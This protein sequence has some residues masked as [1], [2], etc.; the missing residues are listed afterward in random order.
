MPRYRRFADRIFVFLENLLYKTK[1]T[2]SSYGYKAFWGEAFR[3]VELK[4]D[5]FEI[6]A[7]I[8]IKAKKAGLKVIEV[9]SIEEK[10]F[11]GS[12]KLHSLRDGWRILKTILGEKF[13]S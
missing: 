7:E 12:G 8:D 6:E 13:H 2:D 3:R 5:G 1:Y 4:T 9:P 11:S 10:R